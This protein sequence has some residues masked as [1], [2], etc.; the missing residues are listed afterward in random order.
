MIGSAQG[1]ATSNR[2]NSPMMLKVSLIFL[3][4]CI[5]HTT[6]IV[7]AAFLSVEILL[8]VC[9]IF[10]ELHNELVEKKRY[11]V[12]ICSIHYKGSIVLIILLYLL[13]IYCVSI[14]FFVNPIFFCV[15]LK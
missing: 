11:L 15:L 14:F 8:D 3:Y 1:N 2:L 4:Y 12:F 9:S 10:G 5:I 7:T 6:R 13:A